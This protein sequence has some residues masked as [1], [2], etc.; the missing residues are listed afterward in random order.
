M[1]RHAARWG[2]DVRRSV[3]VRR[4]LRGSEGEAAVELFVNSVIVA[5]AAFAFV[6]LVYATLRPERF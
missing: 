4:R 1:D 5:T 6:Y 3:W 2:G